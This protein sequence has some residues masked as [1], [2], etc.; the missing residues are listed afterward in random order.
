MTPGKKSPEEQTKQLTAERSRA[1]LAK[2]VTDNPVYTEAMTAIHT[3][4][5]DAW[6]RTAPHDFESREWL[7]QQAVS[8]MAFKKQLERIMS[9]GSMAQVTMDQKI[10]EVK[11]AAKRGRK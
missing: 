10:A 8:H 3:A 1:N 4:L 9:T 2:M 5:F 11:I 6:M 7:H